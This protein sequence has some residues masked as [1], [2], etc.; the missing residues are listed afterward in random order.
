VPFD[1]LKLKMTAPEIGSRP[2]YGA[3][4]GREKLYAAVLNAWDRLHRENILRGT[5]PL[6]AGGSG[7]SENKTS[8]KPATYKDPGDWKAQRQDATKNADLVDK[9]AAELL[10]SAKK[11]EK[12]SSLRTVAAADALVVHLLLLAQSYRQ[13][14]AFCDEM[15]RPGKAAGGDGVGT[16]SLESPNGERVISHFYRQY[17]LCHGGARLKEVAFLGN[18]SGLHA[19]LDVADQ[20]IEKHK[21]TPWELLIRRASVPVFFPIFERPA[22]K[23]GQGSND[24]SRPKSGSTPNTTETPATP[25]RPSRPATA[26]PGQGGGTSTPGNR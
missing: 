17:Y 3:R 2:E 24:R 25:A 4:Y 1:E 16:S 5:P 20:M 9:V 7:L 11:L 10:D 13:L 12:E 21:G 15:I 8:E 22:A 18:L 14:A 26:D 19:A 6:K 23:G